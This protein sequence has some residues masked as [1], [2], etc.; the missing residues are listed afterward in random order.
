M[1]TNPTLEIAGG[2]EQAYLAPKKE[3]SFSGIPIDS[4]KAQTTSEPSLTANGQ[5]PTEIITCEVALR[6]SPTL[7]RGPHVKFED[8]PPNQSFSASTCPETPTPA[9]RS[10]QNTMSTL[11]STSIPIS[12]LCELPGSYTFN[13]LALQHDQLAATTNPEEQEKESRKQEAEHWGVS[14]II[15][16]LNKNQAA[17]KSQTIATNIYQQQ[18]GDP[19]HDFGMVSQRGPSEAATTQSVGPGMFHNAFDIFER[20]I[21]HGG[22]VDADTAED[23]P[24]KIDNVSGVAGAGFSTLSTR[25]TTASAACPKAAEPITVAWDHIEPS[26]MTS[27][28]IN[29]VEL[30]RSAAEPAEAYPDA[31][32]HIASDVYSTLSKDAYEEHPF[33]QAS[34]RLSDGPSYKSE[35]DV[36]RVNQPPVEDLLEDLDDHLISQDLEIGNDR[37]SI[38]SNSPSAWERAYQSQEQSHENELQDLH[39][40]HAA[41][42]EGLNQT[43]ISLQDQLKDAVNRKQHVGKIHQKK[44]D[45]KEHELQKQTAQTDCAVQNCESLEE[46]LKEKNRQLEYQKQQINFLD[47]ESKCKSKLL[48]S[49]REKEISDDKWI[50]QPMKQEIARLS[51]TNRDYYWQTLHQEHDLAALTQRLKDQPNLPAVQAALDNASRDRDVAQSGLERTTQAF[52]QMHDERNKALFE[53]DR[54]TKRL[55]D[56]QWRQDNSDYPGKELLK[57]TQER[58]QDLEKKANTTFALWR[59]K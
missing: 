1:V 29:H 39:E 47:S 38:K 56:V 42:V 32:D 2:P 13:D 16:P 54:L 33:P 6:P 30:E 36:S 28:D 14:D 26:T 40:D 37:A 12:F 58:Y 23:V 43:V 10:T 59:G 4:S 53:I 34:R 21:P 27:C 49:Q 17:D 18:R 50:V 8:T 19:Y 20:Q 41:E 5:A 24:A 52:Q 11:S 9:S 46:Q 55:Q 48:E 35:I 31:E 57:Q 22:R 45:E 44:C 25:E 15:Q 51:H 7:I 3:S